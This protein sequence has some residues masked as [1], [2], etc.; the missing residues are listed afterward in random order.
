MSLTTLL[1]AQGS[2]IDELARRPPRIALRSPMLTAAAAGAAATARP[3]SAATTIDTIFPGRSGSVDCLRAAWQRS[4]MTACAR[5]R[6]RQRALVVLSDRGDRPRA[7]PPVPALL[8]HGGRASR[9]G[10]SR[11]PD[12]RQHRGRYRRRP[13]RASGGRAVRA[14]APPRSARR[15][16]TTPSPR[17]R[18][19]TSPAAT[20]PSARYRLAL[21]R[22]LLTHPV[23]DGRLH[24]QQLLRRA[25][26]RDPRPRR[27]SLVDQLLPGHAVAVA[28]SV[29]AG[30]RSR[31]RS[32]DRHHA[33]MFA[34]AAAAGST[35]PGLHGYRRDGEVPRD[36]SAGRPRAAEGARCGAVA[37]TPR[38]PRQAYATFTSHVYGRP[39]DGGAGSAGDSTPAVAGVALDDVEPVDA[40][41]RRFFASAMSVG[42]LSPEAHRTIATR[43]EPARRAQ[44]QRRGRRRAGPVRAGR[45]HG[46]WDGS[47]TKQVASARFGVTPALSA[48]GRRAADQDRAGLEAGRGRSAAGAEGDAAHRAAAPRAAGNDR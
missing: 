13:R 3:R 42:A 12:A 23:E 31:R 41:C 37:P 4:R 16:A 21:E 6:A 29:D 27:A 24:V 10:R 11:P 17:W 44:Q 22:G 7:A 46:D 26:V 43:D 32:L 1:G 28:G 2:F 25:A 20:S 36:Q 39:A 48:I 38:R 35:I 45:R 33:R 15:S 34:T 8:A 9:A 18:R 40:I 47:R 14:A 30:R 5:G 19:S